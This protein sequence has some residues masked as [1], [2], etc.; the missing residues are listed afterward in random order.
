MERPPESTHVIESDQEILAAVHLQ[1]E[2]IRWHHHL[3]H[4]PLSNVSTL[5]L[6]V[7]IPCKPTTGKNPKC[8]G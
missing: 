2:L 1:E 4:L 6:L 3:G 7:I 8:I 5:A